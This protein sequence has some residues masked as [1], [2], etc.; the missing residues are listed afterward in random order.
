MNRLKIHE[1]NGRKREIEFVGYNREH[2]ACFVRD[3]HGARQAIALRLPKSFGLRFRENPIGKDGSPPVEIKWAALHLPACFSSKEEKEAYGNPDSNE[4]LVAKTMQHN[5]WMVVTP[6]KC[7]L[8]PKHDKKLSALHRD[9]LNR[10]RRLYKIREKETADQIAALPLGEVNR[11]DELRNSLRNQ[12]TTF[13]KGEK[14]EF[15]FLS[16]FDTT[17]DMVCHGWGGLHEKLLEKEWAEQLGLDLKRIPKDAAAFHAW[18]EHAAYNAR[19]RTTDLETKMTAIGDGL[20]LCPWQWEVLE[21]S[22]VYEIRFADGTRCWLDDIDEH[23]VNNPQEVEDFDRLEESAEIAGDEKISLDEV[24][25]NLPVRWKGEFRPIGV[26]GLRK[27]CEKAGVMFD[28][29]M[30]R[31]VVKRLDAHRH[32]QNR[33][34]TERLKSYRAKA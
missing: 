27:L 28:F 20:Q 31:S 1:W 18:L 13:T 26:K 21:A 23:G 5:L 33:K 32:R 19:V 22:I 4:V 14:S 30:R 7:C 2:T 25:R 8:E 17:L 3:D 34:R 29:P 11:T 6:H 24:R 12:F 15:K 10:Q 16:I 9:E